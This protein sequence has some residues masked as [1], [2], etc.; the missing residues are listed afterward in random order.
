MPV[1][2][3][4]WGSPKLLMHNIGTKDDEWSYLIAQYGYNDEGKTW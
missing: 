3:C 2:Q 1:I 4:S